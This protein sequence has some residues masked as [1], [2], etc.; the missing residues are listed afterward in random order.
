M[1][2]LDHL[3]D[4]VAAGPQPERGLKHLK[5]DF[6][7]HLNVKGTLISCCHPSFISLKQKM[8]TN[9]VFVFVCVVDDQISEREAGVVSTRGLCRC[10]RAPGPRPQL[11]VLRMLS[12][13]QRRRGT[14][15]GGACST[16]E[17]TSPLRKSALITLTGRS[18]IPPLS[19]T[20]NHWIL[21]RII[22]MT[23]IFT[24]L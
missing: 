22:S 15:F 10:R 12:H 24:L 2:L 7:K 16:P 23:S 6:S 8:C 9:P 18:Q 21:L 11:R 4:D 20:G 1:V 19:M 13:P 17:A 3:W 5:K 14:M